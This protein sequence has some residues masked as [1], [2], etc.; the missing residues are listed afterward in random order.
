MQ[1][2]RKVSAPSGIMLVISALMALE[3]LNSNFY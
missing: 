1:A 3:P 2:V